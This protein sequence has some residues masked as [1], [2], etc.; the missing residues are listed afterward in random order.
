MPLAET[1]A[2][3]PHCQG[4]GLPPF[5]RVIRLAVYRD[6]LKHL[7]HQIKYH[8][9]WPLAEFLADRLLEQESVKGLLT[10][11]HCLAPVPLHRLR[12]IGRGY[13]QAEV[14]A[15]RLAKRCDVKL[16]SPAVR[17]RHTE[18]QTHLHSRAQRL[19]NLRD[20]FGLIR[21]RSIRDKHVVI[22]DDVMTT[23]ATLLSL[24]HVLRKAEPAS[25]SAIVV[26]L[27]DPHGKDFQTI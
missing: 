9:R 13:N 15:G 12:Q 26:A 20:A 19:E 17:L 27:A 24:A 6:P 1:G 3:C 4:E 21:P 7:V 14:I 23:G 25:L 8:R 2:P 16:V 5:E 10:F 18:T 22:I 11:T